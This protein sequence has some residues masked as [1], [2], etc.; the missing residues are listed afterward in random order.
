MNTYNSVFSLMKNHSDIHSI[1]NATLETA[2]LIFLN[3]DKKNRQF[4]TSKN[5][6]V[7]GSICLSVSSFYL[8]ENNHVFYPSIC[9]KM[10]D[11]NKQESQLYFSVV[12]DSIKNLKFRNFVKT[13]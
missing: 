9:E 10:F 1:T 5:K 6:N 12:L 3:L 13:P 11:I 2:I 7:I 8:E 4:L